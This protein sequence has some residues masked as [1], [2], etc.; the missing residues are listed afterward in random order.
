RSFAWASHFLAVPA[1][2]IY[3]NDDPQLTLAA[4]V[5]EEPTV[6]AGVKAQRGRTLPELAFLVGRH[7]A[8]HVGAHRLLLYY[9]SIEEI[10]A[11]FLA[12]LPPAPPGAPAPPGMARSVSELERGIALRI[13]EDHRVDLAAA[14]AAFEAAGSR[15]HL[16]EWAAD[17][18]RCATRAG[19]LLAADL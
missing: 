2:D 18:E 9:P 14:V 17:V 5:A 6:F 12:P 11:S 8:Y 19:F 3:L 7:L 16:A 13:S 1:P 4:V 10:T 15:S